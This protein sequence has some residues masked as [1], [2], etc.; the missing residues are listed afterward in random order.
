MVTGAEESQLCNLNRLVSTLVIFIIGPE[1]LSVYF[2]VLMGP[3]R[4]TAMLLVRLDSIFNHER[5]RRLIRMQ[6]G[7]EFPLCMRSKG[8]FLRA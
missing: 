1:A 8:G 6:A 4:F 2:L 3:I 7:C 5:P